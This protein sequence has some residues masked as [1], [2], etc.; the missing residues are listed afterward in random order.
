VAKTIISLLLLVSLAACASSDIDLMRQDI[1]D[2]KRNSFEM[3]KELNVLRQKTDAATKEVGSLKMGKEGSLGAVREGQAEINSR[4]TEI[5]QDLQSLRGRFEENK[6]YVEKTLKDSGTDRDL[7][8]T[9]IQGL[10]AQVKALRDR[11]GGAP[12]A[13]A[14]TPGA[15][16]ALSEG[17]KK[18][19]LSPSP[20]PSPGE[21]APGQMKKETAPA[22]QTAPAESASEERVKAY[23]EAY[24]AFKDKKY[25]E[26]RRKFE[27]FIKNYPK[28]DLTD[29]AQ[30]WIGETYYAEKDYEG[31]ILA[32][33]TLLKKYPG[34]AK[35]S[36][37]MLKQGLAFTDIGDAKTGTIILRRLI[38]KFPDS[39]EA[40]VA[41]KK[42]AQ[43]E[44]KP[45]RKK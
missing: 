36:A 25:K 31:A 8:R 40:A 34:S 32:Y 27:S 3:Q 33:E 41:R 12:E 13:A 22:E 42:I 1:N 37:A 6:Y 21:K 2:L 23:D 30:F 10:E 14:P 35:T 5:S 45:G 7:L 19:S 38:E 11:L 43:L 15:Q 39:K 44:K 9:Q 26:A 29:N 24:Q 28:N 17:P 4:L 16:A 20:S 18:P